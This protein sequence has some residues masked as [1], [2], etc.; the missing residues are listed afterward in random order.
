[1]I[2]IEYGFDPIVYAL[3][4]PKYHLFKL[5]RK[6]VF[7][8]WVFYFGQKII[9]AI[10]VYYR[11]EF[12]GK[13]PVN[14]LREDVAA[15]VPA[16]PQINNC[17]FCFELNYNKSVKVISME[18]EYNDG[19]CEP[20]F[21][22]DVEFVRHNKDKFEKWSKK[23]DSLVMP[24]KD[25]V[26][27][28]QG[29][30]NVE[31]YKNSILPAVLNIY[32]YLK[33]SGIEIE[34]N[35][36][37]LD[38]GCGSGRILKGWYTIMPEL[39]LRGCDYNQFLVDWNKRYLPGVIQ[40]T[41]NNLDPASEYSDDCFDFIYIISV[42]T[43]LKLDTQRKWIAEIERILK[44][45]GLL[46]IT[47]H[48]EFYMRNTYYEQPEKIEQFLELG[49]YEPNTK[50]GEGENS[51]GTFHGI[52]FVQNMFSNFELIRFFPQGNTRSKRK[53]FQIAL[54][55]DVYVMRYKGHSL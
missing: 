38:F 52:N 6:N 36:R 39:D 33:D 16:L 48:G 41:K 34:N 8:G 21:E 35:F 51:F 20:F 44:P 27:M 23:L 19:D 32:G 26:Y 11:T 1:M 50:E 55:Q 3:E 29:H 13:H 42:F 12:I 18:I 37:I 28:T 10:N 54:A 17:G 24:D 7:S 53:I 43:H 31:E 40:I 22:Y 14:I 49:Y 15:H 5:D 45:G 46:L 9:Q 25:T 47:L 2:N 30:C 4:S